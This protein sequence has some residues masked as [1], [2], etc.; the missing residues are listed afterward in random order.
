MTRYNPPRSLV[1]LGLISLLAVHF[2]LRW[3]MATSPFLAET[4]YD[5][6]VTGEMALRLLKGDPQLF[7]W[8]QPYMGALEAYLAGFLFHLFGPTT[9]VLRSTDILICAFI[10]FLINRIGALTGG[11]LVGLLGA[12]Y[13]AFSPLYLSMVGLLATGGHV[14]ACAFGAFVL[15][16]ICWLSFKASKGLGALSALIGITAGL[17]WWSSLLSAPFLLAGG[18][19]LALARPRLLLSRVPWLLLAGFLLGSLPFWL[20]QFRYDFFTFRFFEGGGLKGLTDFLSKLYIVLRFSLFQSC[21]G[22]WWDGHS[23]LP[24]VSPFLAWFIFVVIYLPVFLLALGVVIRWLWRLVNRQ[25]PFQGPLDLVVLTFWALVLSFSASDRGAN[26]SLRYSL[27]LY[28]P[29]TVLVAIWLGWI[30]RF[31]RM[32]GSFVLVGLLSFNLFIHHLF[33]E[34]FKGLPYRPVDHLIKALKDRGIRYVYADSRISQVLTFESREEIIAADY[35]GQRNLYYLRAVDQAPVDQVAIVTH[36][37]LGNPYP[38]TMAASLRLLGGQAERVE[39]GA[40]VFWYHFKEPSEPLRPVSPQNWRFSASQEVGQAQ[41]TKDRD[42]LT[43]WRILKRA[44]DWLSL[45]LGKPRRLGRI[46]LLPGPFEFGLPSGFTIELSQD[47]KKWEKVSELGVN[48][49]LAGLYWY[50][51][52][53]RLDHNPRLQIS[54]PSRL[55]RFLRITNLHT[56]EDPK[57]PLTIAELFV[58][59]VAETPTQPSEKALEAYKQAQDS[60]DHWLDDPT[61]P[62]PLF[63]GVSLEVRRRQVNWQTAMQSLQKAIAEAPDWEEFHQEFGTALDNGGFLNPDGKPRPAKKWDVRS[64]FPH[65]DLIKIPPAR[66]RVSSNRNQSETGLALDGNPLTRWGSLRGQE[67]GLFFQLD[68]GDSFPVG[69]FSL[70]LDSSLNDYPRALIV[71]ASSDGKTWQEIQTTSRTYYAIDGNRIHKKSYYFF[72]PLQVRYLKLSQMGKDP[73]FWWSIYE[74]E[75]YEQAKPRP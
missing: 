8:G 49:M 60:L 46:S 63:P 47:G 70:Y 72:T 52:R 19:G 73:V 13:W 32:V 37:R 62:H 55:A 15:F 66:I 54:F 27:S 35:F 7:F 56:P 74:L 42:L 58:Y 6:A 69:G 4:F 61:G 29:F 39:V 21:L 22:D 26:G 1:L 43:S 9:F 53:P 2:L 41:L 33:L 25:N 16:G 45:D 59:E 68:L 5:E 24:S 75:V 57:D 34:E 23:V 71:T 65:N 51:G 12:A 10:L 20:W 28:V 31:H 50:Q 36:R 17:G 18:V 38:E 67:P 11:G 3:I 44:G 14:E 40:Y 64:L 48:D 30:F